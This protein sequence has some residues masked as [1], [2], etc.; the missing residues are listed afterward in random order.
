MARI[1]VVTSGKGGVGK[2]TTS[3]SPSKKSGMSPKRA[4]SSS[5]S[6]A[7][8]AVFSSRATSGRLALL[9]S[10]VAGVRPARATVID[11]DCC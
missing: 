4:C 3:G 2:T 8:S 11:G 9:I 6:M 5:A 10:K 7:R 1:I